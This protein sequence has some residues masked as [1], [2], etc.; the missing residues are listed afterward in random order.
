MYGLGKKKI[1]SP[2]SCS[3]SLSHT[4]CILSGPIS[5]QVKSKALGIW[6]KKSVTW[7]WDGRDL[8]WQLF[9][10]NHLGVSVGYKPILHEEC[11]V[12]SKCLHSKEV[13]VLGS[14]GTWKSMLHS[15]QA[16]AALWAQQ[17]LGLQGDPTSPFWRRSALGFLWKEWC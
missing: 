10:Q 13:E 6:F 17:S 8:A 5:R 11:D 4:Q 7:V 12:A 1:F 3:L 15:A 16:P 14:V 9:M 2:C